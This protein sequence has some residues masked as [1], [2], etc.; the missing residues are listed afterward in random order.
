[1]STTAAER[2]RDG[3]AVLFALLFPTLVTVVYFVLLAGHPTAWQQGAYSV[4]KVLQ[5][6]LPVVWAL[7]VQRRSISW[8]LPRR[9]ELR[10]GGA[11]GLAILAAML[12]VYFGWMKQGGLPAEA[13]A[14][15]R[16]KAVGIG[17]ASVSQFFALGAFYALGHSLLEEYY[18]RWFVFGQLANLSRRLVAVTL[19]AAGFM[20]HHVCVLAFYFGWNSP[21]GL[22]L[23]VFLSLS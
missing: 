11:L 8:R 23:T 6:G 12:L 5:F 20:A 9:R 15:I 7:L 3:W 17:I 16:D 22:F 18:W 2:R 14:A 1:M 21:T 10:E 13:T 19:S 4:G